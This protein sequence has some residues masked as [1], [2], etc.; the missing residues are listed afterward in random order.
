MNTQPLIAEKSC[1][2]DVFFQKKRPVNHEKKNVST[3]ST[4][5]L[6]IINSLLRGKGSTLFGGDF[7]YTRPWKVWWL[8]RL[9]LSEVTF[10]LLWF[11]DVLDPGEPSMFFHWQMSVH[12]S[13]FRNKFS[14]WISLKRRPPFL[15]AWKFLRDRW[16]WGVHPCIPTITNN[17][18]LPKGLQHPFLHQGLQWHIAIAFWRMAFCTKDAMQTSCCLIT[19]GWFWWIKSNLS[20]FTWISME[21]V[22]TKNN[23]TH[24]WTWLVIERN[25]VDKNGD[26]PSRIW[27]S[28]MNNEV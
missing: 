26:V 16:H 3:S 5:K 4:G 22:Q 19:A 14:T 11:V 17:T 20:K 24:L 6:N 1:L 18:K 27:A 9:K 23:E 8:N 21:T 25:G 10:L 12:H 13:S 2:W 28:L 7:P 15:G